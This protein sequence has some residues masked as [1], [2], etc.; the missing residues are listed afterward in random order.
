MRYCAGGAGF[1]SGRYRSCR[2]RLAAVPAVLVII[3]VCAGAGLLAFT[4]A[5]VRLGVKALGTPAD[6]AA[7]N[8]MLQSAAALLGGRFRDRLQY[9]WYRRPAQYGAVEGELCGLG[10][11]LYLMPWNAEDCGGAAMLH[12]LPSQDRLPAGNKPGRTVFF[13]LDEAWHWPDRADPATLASYVRQAIAAA[14][15]GDM[16][17]GSPWS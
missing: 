5:M 16:P 6:R 9:P 15:A 17:P 12:I 3:T 7:A 4:G 1:T 14:A 10:Y 13:T 11:G 2:E 8:Q